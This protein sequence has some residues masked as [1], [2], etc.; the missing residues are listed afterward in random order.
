MKIFFGNIFRDAEK[1]ISS[2][3]TGQKSTHRIDFPKSCAASSSNKNS[4]DNTMTIDP[5]QVAAP[6][7]SFNELQVKLQKNHRNY[8][9]NY[10]INIGLQRRSFRSYGRVP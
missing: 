4:S 6:L 10:T 2:N 5:M 7:L 3:F 9:I 1:E 8:V